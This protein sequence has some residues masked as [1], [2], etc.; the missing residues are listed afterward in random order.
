M[1]DIEPSE[2]GFIVEKL[3]VLLDLSRALR[4]LITL[5]QLLPCI[6]AEAKSCALL[7]LDKEISG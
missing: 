6:I 3:A 1:S 2:G 4:A 7:L 5:D